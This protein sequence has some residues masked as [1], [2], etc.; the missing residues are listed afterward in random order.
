MSWQRFPNASYPEAYDSDNMVD[1][2]D[3]SV[4]EAG[5][6]LTIAAVADGYGPLLEMTGEDV[7]GVRPSD[8]MPQPS[9]EDVVES[10]APLVDDVVV[11]EE[12]V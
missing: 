7:Q 9:V 10:S 5:G 12:D 8:P 2:T 6:K 4:N 3:V 11:D 1:A